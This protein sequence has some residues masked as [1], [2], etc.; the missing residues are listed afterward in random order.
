VLE[1][2][3]EVDTWALLPIGYPL[4]NFGPVKRKPIHE[5]A[6]LDRWGNPWPD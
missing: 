2:P 6:C 3:R 4:D 5:V 1:I